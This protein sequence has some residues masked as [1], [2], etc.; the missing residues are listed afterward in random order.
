MSRNRVLPV[1]AH[2]I[3]VGEYLVESL[4]VPRDRLWDGYID[5]M[6]RG[7]LKPGVNVA[8]PKYRRN[9]GNPFAF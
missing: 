6:M 9:W 1:P 4:G 7:M 3:Q 8:D 5:M 2:R